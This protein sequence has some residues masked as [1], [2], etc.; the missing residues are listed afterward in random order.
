[1]S[2]RSAEKITI[3]GKKAKNSSAPAKM[4]SFRLRSETINALQELKIKAN[5]QSNIPIS[6]TD[7]IELLI[8]KAAKDGINVILDNINSIQTK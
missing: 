7:I 1:M 3:L 5:K 8:L 2:K 4:K 6:A